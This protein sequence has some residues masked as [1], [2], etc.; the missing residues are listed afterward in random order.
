[1]LLALVLLAA[2]DYWEQGRP[3]SFVSLQPVL[4]AGYA[5]LVAQAGWG[6]PGWMWGGAEAFAFGGVGFAAEYAG[7]RA[8]LLAV[9]LRAG[10]RHTTSF[11]HGALQ[12]M[13]AHS[14]DDFT[15]AQPHAAY[16]T[17]EA[18][19]SGG[20]PLPGGFG[21]WDFEGYRIEGAPASVDLY[22]EWMKVV[23]RP[24]WVGAARAGYLLALGS[25]GW[26]KLGALADFT[27]TSGR[28]TLV[29]VGPLVAARLTDHLDLVVLAAAAVRTPDA[30]GLI[31]GMYGTVRLRWIWA[32]GEERPGFR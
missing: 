11:N 28:D 1:V 23:V 9:D 27:A 2:P 7:V 18:E 12:P 6:R 8:D 10:V 21:L 16:T 26:L 20:V 25:D 24:P 30:L 13:P 17:L 19:L 31:G 5:Q 14:I 4:G 3:R 32:S 22:E 15:A 29:R